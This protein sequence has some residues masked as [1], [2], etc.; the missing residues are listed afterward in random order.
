MIVALSAM[1]VNE[2][3]RFYELTIKPFCHIRPEDPRLS[4]GTA[5]ACFS[6]RWFSLARFMRGA[7]LPKGSTSSA[8]G[9]SAADGPGGPVKP[10]GPAHRLAVCREPGTGRSEGRIPEGADH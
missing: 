3:P 4:D 1:N 2:K 8:G 6:S 10:T 5:H 9:S 7:G